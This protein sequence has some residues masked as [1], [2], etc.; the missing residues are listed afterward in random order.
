MNYKR[1]T[2][3]CGKDCFNCPM[4]TG[5]E[6]KANREAFF[7]S[8]NIPLDKFQCKGCRDN[9]GYCEGL[10][11]LGIDP[12]CKMYQCIQNKGVEFCYECDEFPC[13]RLQPL[14][15][16]AERVPHALKIFNLC[17]IQKHG[18]EKW[19]KEMSKQIFD[20]YYT[21]KLDSCM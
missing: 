7:K 21:R 8:R 4:Y 5:E 3:P 1:L 10:K 15:D 20:D 19:G 2:A 12:N 11:I 16:R 9:N 17:L 6:N 13:D 18:V 14:S